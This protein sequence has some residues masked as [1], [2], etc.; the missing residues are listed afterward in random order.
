MLISAT[1]GFIV[2]QKARDCQ[3]AM[4]HT[5]LLCATRVLWLFPKTFYVTMCG[6]GKMSVKGGTLN[7]PH[8]HVIPAVETGICF[9]LRLGIIPV[10]NPPA[11]WF[12]PMSPI[13]TPG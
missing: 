10:K 12:H 2:R 11:S 1:I 7:A 5:D 4:T 6:I 3:V 13:E 8:K 9:L